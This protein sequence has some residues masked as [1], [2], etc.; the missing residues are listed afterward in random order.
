V[1]KAVYY[2]FAY[3]QGQTSLKKRP[4][5]KIKT[6]TKDSFDE[7]IDRLIDMKS[8]PAMSSRVKFM[9]QDII[10]VRDTEWVKVFDEFVVKEN[11]TN[12]IVFHA[13]EMPKKKEA[14]KEEKAPMLEDPK[15]VQRELRKSSLNETNILG[16]GL[17][18]YASVKLDE[19][20][21]VRV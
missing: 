7:Y 10:E 4:K 15:V 11:D 8:N 20:T 9:I 19:A 16:I 2:F 14:H 13:K 21:R 1:G 5:L 3:S 12:K 18:V 6:L 17:E